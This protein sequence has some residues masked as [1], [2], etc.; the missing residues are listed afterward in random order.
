MLY[1]WHSTAISGA[2]STQELAAG[3]YISHGLG[4]KGGS[5][6]VSRAAHGNGMESTKRTL[7]KQASMATVPYIHP[8]TRARCKITYSVEIEPKNEGFHILRAHHTSPLHPPPQ[9]DCT[10]GWGWADDM[11]IPKQSKNL[12]D[13]NFPLGVS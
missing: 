2:P 9:D 12:A 3:Q 11:E 5:E 1:R 8:P 7:C 13:P 10:R 4:E 6:R